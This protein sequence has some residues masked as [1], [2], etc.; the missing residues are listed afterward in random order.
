MNKIPSFY[1]KW[2]YLKIIQH[3]ILICYSMCCIIF[4]SQEYVG[5]YC[6]QAIIKDNKIIKKFWNFLHSIG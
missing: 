3:L 5:L 2:V 4:A 1:L 6:I